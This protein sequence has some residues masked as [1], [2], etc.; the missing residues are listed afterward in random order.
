MVKP[1][2]H[3]VPDDGGGWKNVREGSK[4]A[5]AKFDKK[6]EAEAAGRRTAQRDKV[7]YI[8]HKRDGTIGSRSSY[9]NDP[10]PPKG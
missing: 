4:R 8:V 10:Y 9:G 1:A 3:T 7:E 2:V 6:T 5:I